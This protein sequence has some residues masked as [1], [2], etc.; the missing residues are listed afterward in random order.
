MF[1]VASVTGSVQIYQ[2]S[3]RDYSL[4]AEIKEI[5]VDCMYKGIIDMCIH[6]TFSTTILCILGHLYVL[7]P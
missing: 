5:Q 1:A 4:A 2:G 6:N 7:E 3:G